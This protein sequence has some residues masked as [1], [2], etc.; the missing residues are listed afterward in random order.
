MSGDRI[1]V[2][3]KFDNLWF[4]PFKV[5][6]ILDNNTFLLENLEHNHSVEGPVNGSF[7]KHFFAC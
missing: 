6:S 3:T 7:L 4:G 2:S 5:S 1:E